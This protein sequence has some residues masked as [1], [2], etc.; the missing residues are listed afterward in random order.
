MLGYS[1]VKLLNG[2]A[3]IALHPVEGQNMLIDLCLFQAHTLC[4]SVDEI[5]M[6]AIL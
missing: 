4:E 5:D 2:C 3:T 6:L 1:R